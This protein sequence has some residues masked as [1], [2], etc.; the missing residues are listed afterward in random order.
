VGNDLMLVLKLD[1][2]RGIRKQFRDHAGKFQEFF[3]RH[4]LSERFPN[5]AAR[6][7]HSPTPPKSVRNLAE[8]AARHNHADKI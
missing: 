5:L 6:R 1:P 4:S 7:P 8:G 3:L 2:K